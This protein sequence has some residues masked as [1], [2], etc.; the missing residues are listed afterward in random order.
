MGHLVLQSQHSSQF[1]IPRFTHRH[2]RA[3]GEDAEVAVLFVGIDSGHLLDVDDI[4][5]VCA[6]EAIRVEDL[7]EIAH[8]AVLEKGAVVRVD[9]DVIVGSFEVV[10]VFNGD[11]LY[12]S[13]GFD[14]DALLLG[15][16]FG[17]SV[18]K[19]LGAGGRANAGGSGSAGGAGSRLAGGFRF[20][21]IQPFSNGFV[22]P[23]F[24]ERF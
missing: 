1:H 2:L 17:G 20:M 6:D 14:D 4:G 19:G 8:R 3:G 21:P 15:R 12:F 10:D 23:L 18:Q 22:K 24:G 5:A 7:F 13:R 16:G 9:L 11:D